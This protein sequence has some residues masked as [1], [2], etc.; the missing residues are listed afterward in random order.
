[1]NEDKRLKKYGLL[2][3]KV[4]YDNLDIKPT[5]LLYFAGFDQ[6]TKV[7]NSGW[8]CDEKV[9][10]AA[11]SIQLY[12]NPHRFGKV[13]KIHPNGMVE[14]VCSREKKMRDRRPPPS[15]AVR[16]AARAHRPPPPAHAGSKAKSTSRP[17]RP[18]TFSW[19]CRTA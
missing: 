12:G 7:Y 17:A 1:M 5:L 8:S 4:K 15:P 18:S 10:E 9:Q 13:T 14:C 16:P 11:Y 6:W 2:N 3:Y 19:R